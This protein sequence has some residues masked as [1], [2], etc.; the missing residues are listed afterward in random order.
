MCRAAPMGAPAATTAAAAAETAP[1]AEMTTANAKEESSKRGVRCD[2][3]D[4]I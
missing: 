4:A 2:P 1:A 3:N